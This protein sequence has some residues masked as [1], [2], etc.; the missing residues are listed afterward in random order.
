MK[1]FPSAEK[2][3]KEAR[4]KDPK[5]D[6]NKLHAMTYNLI[7]RYRQV[8]YQNK[9]RNLFIRPSLSKLPEIVKIRLKKE[10]LK[11]IKVK[12]KIYSNFMEEAARRISQTLQPISGNI[13]ELCVERELIEKGLKLE[14]NYR[15]KREH[16]DLII[17]YPQL[18]NSS[19]KH[20]VEVKNVK[21]RERGTRGFQFDGDSLIGFFDTPA[22]F[23]DNNIDIIN[24]HCKETGGYCYLPPMILEELRKKINNKRFR[25]NTDFASDMKRFVKTGFI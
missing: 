6:I 11:P 17:Y 23:T 8:Y 15:K 18:K 14:K 22:E 1:K 4:K 24:A 5:A 20:R 2:I 7:I 19:K 12:N 3:I 21:L 10:L 25:S 13:A 16:T 9:I